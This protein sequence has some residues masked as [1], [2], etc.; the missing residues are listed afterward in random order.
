MTPSTAADVRPSLLVVDDD[1]RVRTVVC[2]QL[3]A[4][5][6]AVQRGRRRQ[7]RLA[8]HRRPPSR[9]GRARPVAARACPAST[10]C[11]GCATGDRT[12]VVV[13]SGRRRRGRPDPRAGPRRRRL[14][15]QAV[16]PRRA[17]RPGALGAAPSRRAGRPRPAGGRTTAG[18]SRGAAHRPVDARGRARRRAGR[19]DRPRVRPARLPRRAP[20]PGVH[21]AP[22]CWSRSGPARGGWQS[23]ATVTE[24]VH[25]LRHKLG[26]RP[27]GHR[28]R[29]RLPA[30]TMTALDARPR[31][32]PTRWRCWPGR[33]TSSSRSPPA[34][35]WAT[36]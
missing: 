29:R 7:R 12:P 13:L 11:A 5:G 23:E 31:A 4:E 33:P 25:R 24:H 35:R 34:S 20:A 6:Y 15:G 10:C 26:P 14:P 16:L 30:G 9:S 28:P 8:G 22:S 18:A 1:S 19:A 3:E 17:R 32:R 27:P 36:C 2:W 21:P